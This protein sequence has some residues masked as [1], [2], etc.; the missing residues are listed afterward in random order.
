L[1]QSSSTAWPASGPDC[2]P[3]KS[4]ECAVADSAEASAT[5]A[6]DWKVKEWNRI[7][8]VAPIRCAGSGTRSVAGSAPATASGC[9]T[10]SPSPTRWIRQL[11]RAFVQVA[12]LGALLFLVLGFGW[13][14]WVALIGGLVM[15]LIYSVAYIDQSAEH[16]SSSRD[17]RRARSN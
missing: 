8:D 3:T 14:T 1:K 12:P 5:A 16:R 13:I 7:G 11:A 2:K 9:C 10:T 4:A 17:T 15:A 6:Q